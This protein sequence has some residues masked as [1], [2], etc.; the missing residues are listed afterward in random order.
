MEI[1]QHWVEWLLAEIGVE[2]PWMA[3]LKFILL[4]LILITVAYLSFLLARWL[5]IKFVHPFFLR[6]ATQWDDILVNFRVLSKLG[7]IVPA[8]ILK[9]SVPVLFTDFEY[10]LPFVIRL[11]DVY[12]VVVVMMVSVAF[13]KALE[14]FL[15][16]METFR[17][18]PL[19]SYFQLG[20]IIV[21]IIA[22]IMMLSLI[23]GRSPLYFVSAFGA[24]TAI[25]LLIF[26]DTILGLVASVQI[27][28]NDTIRV[29]DWVEMPKYN[30]DGDVIAMNLNTVKIR[31]F[32]KTITSVPTY[33]FVSDSFKNWRGMKETGAR[34]IKR[35]I[36]INVRSV[37]F[38]DPAMRERFKRYFLIHEFVSRRQLEIERYNEENQVD[39]REL[40][41]GRR[42]TNL[43]VFRHY[44]EAYLRHDKRIRTDL[45]L[46]VRQLAAEGQGLPIEIYCFAD[47]TVWTA[48]ETIQSDI[49]DH[50]IAAAQHF[51]LEVF[52]VP[53]GSDI[54]SAGEQMSH[55]MNGKE[56]TPHN[57]P[58]QS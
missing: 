13:L 30:A 16:T 14:F 56:A 45:T 23:L 26:K 15:G 36:F 38:V 52:Q 34:R 27:S 8:F 18:K 47:T 55:L 7:L 51:D 54:V 37:K 57:S 24:M 32:D 5:I 25:I 10:L 41:N 19:A 12:I 20:R 6:T 28:S 17:D 50:L 53:G 33:Y 48:Y 39:T 49:F 44:A 31:N 21:Y 58:K 29:G 4:A 43:G 9:A 42:M 46:L 35:A 2:S 1:I 11:T 3:Y 40:I 22:G